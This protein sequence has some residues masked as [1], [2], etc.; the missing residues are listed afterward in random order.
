[1]S[2]IEQYK[3]ERERQQK[4]YIERKGMI[5]RLCCFILIKIFTFTVGS[6]SWQKRKRYA[7]WERSSFQKRSLCPISTGHSFPEGKVYHPLYLCTCTSLA[8]TSFPNEARLKFL[9]LGWPLPQLPSQPF[10]IAPVLYAILSISMP[11]TWICYF[12]E[13]FV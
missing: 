10:V 7:D 9:E 13:G 11:Q 5:L 8:S 3:M 12:S 2:L 1:M 6:C 4:V